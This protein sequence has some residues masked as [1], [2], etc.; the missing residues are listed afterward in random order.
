MKTQLEASPLFSKVEI[1]ETRKSLDGNQVEFR[2]RL[3]LNGQGG[4]S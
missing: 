4:K 2:L 3:Q 1:T